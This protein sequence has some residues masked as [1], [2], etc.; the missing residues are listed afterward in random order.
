MSEIFMKAFNVEGVEKLVNIEY[1]ALDRTE[2]K[3]N[4]L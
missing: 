4:H 2:I 1:R 3:T